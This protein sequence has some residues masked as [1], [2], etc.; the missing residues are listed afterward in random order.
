MRA[1][2]GSKGVV[3]VNVGQRCK[4]LC[5]FRIVTLFLGVE[6]YVFQ[7]QKVAVAQ[8]IHRPLRNLAHTIGGKG[9]GKAEALRKRARNRLQRVPRIG[10]SVG[11]AEMR[12]DDRA[13]AAVVQPAQRR[14][15]GIDARVVD[16][17]RSV[18]GNV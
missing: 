15:R 9:N 10:F 13:R 8:R 16:D 7:Q 6:P 18:K 1:V 3:H 14:K 12:A 5:E 17:L 11:A 4:P 2:R